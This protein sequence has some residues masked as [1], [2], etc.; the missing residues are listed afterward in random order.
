MLPFILLALVWTISCNGYDSAAPQHEARQ[1]ITGKSIWKGN[2]GG[3]QIEWTSD[4]LFL[5]SGERVERILQPL[6]RRG[7]DEFVAD[8]SRN[9]QTTQTHNCD[10]RRDFRVLSIV[11][12]LLAL[13]DNQYSDCGGAHPTTELRF[14]LIDLARRGEVVYRYDQTFLDADLDKPNRIARLSEHFPETA[15]LDALLADRVIKQAL[16][17]AGVSTPRTLLDLPAVFAKD[18]YLLSDSELSLRPDFLTRV[19]FHHL[20][21]DRVAVRLNLPSI[22]FA[23]RS[24]QIGLLLPVPPALKQPL[25]LAATGQE[26]FLMSNAPSGTR[27]QFTRFDF[28]LGGG[29][30]RAN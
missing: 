2:S 8:L 1:E 22:A 26:G 14:T 6:A 28:K 10:Y 21:D 29:A 15:I 25:A 30:R 11:G 5:R 4:D 9:D 18:D 3:F 23:Y 13:E 20:E 16:T 12:P 24:K 17:K 7:Y 27:N 19:A